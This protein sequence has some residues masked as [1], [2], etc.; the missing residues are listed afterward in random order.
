ML[1]L[2]FFWS[3][4]IP[5][6][7]PLVS[8]IS[9][10]T[11]VEAPVDFSPLYVQLD[12]LLVGETDR[13]ELARLREC[14]R[15]MSTAK[16]WD[17]QVQK[18]IYRFVERFLDEPTPE[19]RKLETSEPVEEMEFSM[20]TI[21]IEASEEKNVDERVRQAQELAQTGDLLGAIQLLEQCRSLPCW[22]DVYIHWAKFSDMEFLR[23]VEEIKSN[24]RS[25]QEERSLWEKLLEDFPH[26]TY[27]VQI[28]KELTRIES[29]TDVP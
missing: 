29:A 2:L 19:G 3:C 6:G 24:K 8:H 4:V 5:Y 20:D 21:P 28:Q 1:N 22:S 18:E 13:F 27:Q 10:N 23:R 9:E 25:A 14:E 17:P 26:P 16:S 11:I 12:Q 7:A 15:L